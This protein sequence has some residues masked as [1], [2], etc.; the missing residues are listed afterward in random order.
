M[1]NGQRGAKAQ[2]AVSASAASAPASLGHAGLTASSAS[3]T[4]GI[5]ESS[6]AV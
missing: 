3:D 5:A 4:T 1:A 6:I 2:P